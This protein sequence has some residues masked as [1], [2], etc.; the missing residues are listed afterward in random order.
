M[1]SVTVKQFFEYLDETNEMPEARHGWQRWDGSLPAYDYKNSFLELSLVDE[2]KQIS[3]QGMS[4]GPVAYG[5]ENY[6]CLY[7]NKNTKQFH[8]SDERN[9]LDD[10]LFQSIEKYYLSKKLASDLPKKTVKSRGKI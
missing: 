8:F 4:L 6:F 7:I 5:P 1:K 2:G 10:R 3:V 9:E